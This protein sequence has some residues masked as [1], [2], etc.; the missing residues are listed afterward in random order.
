MRNTTS[1]PG[2]WWVHL[3]IPPQTT[4]VSNLRG[5]RIGQRG[6]A[7]AVVA[8]E[9]LAINSKPWFL[10]QCA[11]GSA[12]PGPIRP[13]VLPAE[14]GAWTVEAL[15]WADDPR[16]SAAAIL[17]LE[18]ALSPTPPG[19]IV[20]PLPLDKAARIVNAYRIKVRSGAFADAL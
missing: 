11:A 18:G 12:F 13:V 5:F 19:E 20:P 7:F 16:L 8:D 2:D 9:L 14:R 17:A 3:A 1:I 15:P 10:A 6:D 4:T